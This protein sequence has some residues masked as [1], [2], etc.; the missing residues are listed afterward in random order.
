MS[1]KSIAGR[2]YAHYLLLPSLPAQERDLAVAAIEIA[3]LNAGEHFHVARIDVEA[4]ELLET[5][6]SADNQEGVRA[7]LEKRAPRF[8][9]K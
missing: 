5:I 4:R 2:K 9:G 7:F 8:T 3:C 1:G 6:R